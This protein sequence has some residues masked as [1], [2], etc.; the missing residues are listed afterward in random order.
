MN[1]EEIL[2]YCEVGSPVFKDGE[3]YFITQKGTFNMKTFLFNTDN[4]HEGLDVQFNSIRDFEKS[5][6][7]RLSKTDMI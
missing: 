3:K 2:I 4:P 5:S 6:P 1:K 7:K